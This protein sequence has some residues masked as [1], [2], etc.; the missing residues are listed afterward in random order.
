MSEKSD[1]SIRRQSP[2]LCSVI[3]PRGEG[4]IGVILLCGEGAREVLDSCFR[5][6]KRNAAQISP[7]RL[8]HGRIVRNGAVIDEVVVANCPSRH[9]A[10]DLPC[11]E[12]NCHGGAMA[13]KMVL[14]CF[15]DAGARVVHWREIMNRHREGETFV[16]SAD[17]IRAEALQLLP[18]AATRLVAGMLLHQADGAL[19]R[20]LAY[21]A[22]ALSGR[23]KDGEERLRSLVSGAEAGMAMTDPPAVMLAGPPNAGKST[24]LNALLQRER[25]IVHPTPGTTRDVVRDRLSVNGMPFNLMDSAGIRIGSDEIEKLAV[26]HTLRVVNQADVIL[27]VFD[28]R[29]AFQEVIATA[30]GLDLDGKH[31]LCVANKCDLPDAPPAPE[32]AGSR[33]SYAVVAISAKEGAGLEKIRRFLLTP[34]SDIMERS[35]SGGPVVFTRTQRDILESALRFADSGRPGEAARLLAE[36][37]AGALSCGAREF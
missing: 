24:L 29:D 3:T 18:E 19:S 5:G 21:I 7:G 30:A 25:V 34:Y 37:G 10:A 12:V 9:S 2:T 31:I 26:E 20:E 23:E 22:R 16:L 28:V 27:F 6:T 15:R 35:A 13:V 11:Y 1:Q 32:R 14:E 17:F 4:G 33:D 36:S 8:A